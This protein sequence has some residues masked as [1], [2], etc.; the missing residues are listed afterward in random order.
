MDAIARALDLVRRC[1][2]E[3]HILCHERAKP[4]LVTKLVEKLESGASP[5]APVRLA[6]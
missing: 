1:P 6:E 5:L 2:L 4:L 3:V